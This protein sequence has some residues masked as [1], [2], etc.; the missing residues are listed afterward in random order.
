MRVI[1]EEGS[2][3]LEHEVAARRHLAH[4][5]DQGCRHPGLGAAGRRART[6]HRIRRRCSGSMRRGRMTSSCWPRYAPRLTSSTP[7]GSRSRSSMSPRPP[8]SRSS[9]PAAGEDTIS[10]TGNVLRDYLTDLFPI[11]ELGTSAKMLSIVPLMERRRLVR[12]R[13]RGFGPQARPA[14][15]AREPPA[16][17]QP[18]RIPGPGRLARD[19]GRQGRA[20]PV[21]GCSAR[22]STAPPGG[23][24]RRTARPRAR[25]GSSTTAAAT[26]TWPCTGRRSWPDRTRIRSWPSASPPWPSGWPTRR[27]RSSPS[28][29]RSRARRSTSA[30]TTGPTPTGGQAAMRP[31]ATFNDA[32]DS[33]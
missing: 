31:S 22:R 32:L 4:V 9:A 28:W 3:L 29:P 27:R 20:T 15:H 10:V 1:D 18:G 2:T 7:T 24:W 23:S 12:D 26:S 17:G 6:G 8:A 33:L 5:S 21:P 25:W 30:A 16:L 19:A 13:R 14:V 11:L